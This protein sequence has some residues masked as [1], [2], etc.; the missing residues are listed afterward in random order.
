MSWHHQ[1]AISNRVMIDRID[2]MLQTPTLDQ[3][4]LLY[5]GQLG[6]DITVPVPRM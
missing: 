1:R 3:G 2:T 5:E 4:E 6:V